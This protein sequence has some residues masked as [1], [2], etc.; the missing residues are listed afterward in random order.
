LEPFQA[1]AIKKG[2]AVSF[3]VLSREVP[4]H[5]FETVYQNIVKQLQGNF[6]GTGIRNMLEAWL[7]ELGVTLLDFVSAPYR[8]PGSSPA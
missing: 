3:V 8:A 4:I 2:F 7:S 6:E 1:R 5:K